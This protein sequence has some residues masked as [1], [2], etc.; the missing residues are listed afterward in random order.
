MGGVPRKV[1]EFYGAWCLESGHPVIIRRN[2]RVADYLIS[3]LFRIRSFAAF[4]RT[5]YLH[6]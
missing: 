2:Y 4:R 5:W 1:R 6:I 3:R